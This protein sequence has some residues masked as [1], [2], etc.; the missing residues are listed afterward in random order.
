MSTEEAREWVTVTYF[1]MGVQFLKDCEQLWNA[2]CLSM[3]DHA[4]YAYAFH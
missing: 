2:N 4:G 1:P 3:E